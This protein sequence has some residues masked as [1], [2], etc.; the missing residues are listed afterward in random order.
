MSEPGHLC[1]SKQWLHELEACLEPKPMVHKTSPRTVNVYKTTFWSM[2]MHQK[3]S[4]AMWKLENFPGIIP[5]DPIAGGDDPLPNPPPAATD[6]Y[7]AAPRPNDCRR[8]WLLAQVEYRIQI[9]EE[10]RLWYWLC[11][12][13]FHF[14]FIV[15]SYHLIFTVFINLGTFWLVSFLTRV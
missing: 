12:A 13:F 5:P 15:I 4:T 8:L 11:S 7:F 2:K 6:R 3:S 9:R 1:D 10:R 14:V